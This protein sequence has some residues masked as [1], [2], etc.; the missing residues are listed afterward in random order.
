VGLTLPE[1][2]RF[3]GGSGWGLSRRSF[4]D[5]KQRRIISGQRSSTM[6]QRRRKCTIILFFIRTRPKEVASPTSRQVSTGIDQSKR[7]TCF[8]LSARQ[9]LC[10]K[11]KTKSFP[12]RSESKSRGKWTKSSIPQTVPSSVVPQSCSSAQRNARL[13]C[14]PVWDRLLSVPYS[15]H[16]LT[17]I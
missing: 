12:K 16:S 15:A 10:R 9:R 14:N 2:P 13:A 3:F 11:K 17:P 8:F 4:D 5:S 1:L 6:K 7:A